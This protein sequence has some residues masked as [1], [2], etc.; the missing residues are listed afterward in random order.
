MD[1]ILLIVILLVVF[2][3]PLRSHLVEQNLEAFLLVAGAVA[4]LAAGLLDGDLIVHALKEPIAITGAV[5]AAG[6]VF[7]WFRDETEALV[8]RIARFVPMPALV[9]GVTIVLGIVSSVITAIVASLFLA[10][11][12]H[13]MRVHR[14]TQAWIA[15]PGCFAIGFGAVLTPIGEPLATVVTSKLSVD[16]WYLAETLWMWVVPAVLVAGGVAAIAVWRLGARVGEAI[17]GE[18]A[19]EGPEDGYRDVVSRAVRVYGFVAGL[20]LLGAAYQP[21]VDR[22][23]SDSPA[24]LMYGAGLISAVLDNAT[25]AAAAVSPSMDPTTTLMF[26]I[27]LMASGGMLIPGNIPNIIA[28]NRLRIRSAEW[29]RVGAPLG[30]AYLVVMGVLL[31]GGQAWAGTAGLGSAAVP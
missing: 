16:F 4:V 3:A 11:L 15:I 29:A 21:L 10:S 18:V 25:L 8:P 5:V 9:A 2:V 14:A 30:I 7:K 1:I 17:N 13:A 6:L 19:P 20:T 12:V 31:A 27:S 24:W 23:L 26:L 28:A 22:Y